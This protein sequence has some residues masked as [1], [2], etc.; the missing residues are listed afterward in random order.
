MWVTHNRLHV[1]TSGMK[2][3]MW[4]LNYRKP[5]KSWRSLHGFY[6]TAWCS[7]NNRLNQ[8]T[9]KDHMERDFSV[10][11]DFVWATYLQNNNK[12]Y[13]ILAK[14]SLSVA[15]YSTKNHEKK[16]FWWCI[17]I[18]MDYEYLGLEQS[19][20][21]QKIFCTGYSA[22]NISSWGHFDICFSTSILI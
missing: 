20:P 14:R 10:G 9:W 11:P 2:S 22:F 19:V 18:E 17:K 8:R 13:N 21:S 15:I 1:C 5:K 3:S 7:K 6:L 12:F 4:T 16:A